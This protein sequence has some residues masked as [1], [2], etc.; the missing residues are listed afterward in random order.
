M[1]KELK[2]ALQIDRVMHIIAASG[3]NVTPLLAGLLLPIFGRFLEAP[4]HTH[5]GDCWRLAVIVWNAGRP[6]PT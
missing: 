3:M 4:A 6:A 2:T 1:D 5:S